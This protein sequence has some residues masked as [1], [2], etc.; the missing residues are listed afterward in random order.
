MDEILYHVSRQCDAGHISQSCTQQFYIPKS[1]TAGRD[2]Y[3]EDINEKQNMILVTKRR[4]RKPFQLTLVN[5]IKFSGDRDR[6][7]NYTPAE[8]RVLF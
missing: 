4:I 5:L 8:R 3:D 2:L 6:W 7:I 1:Q